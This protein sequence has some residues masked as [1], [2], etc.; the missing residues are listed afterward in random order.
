M[1]GKMVILMV[2]T[3][4]T[5]RNAVDVGDSSLLLRDTGVTV[6]VAGIHLRL[7]ICISFYIADVSDATSTRQ[8]RRCSTS[9][10]THI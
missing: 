8:L 1:L 3:E 2:I 10:S 6:T 4:Y 9:T 5:R 7:V